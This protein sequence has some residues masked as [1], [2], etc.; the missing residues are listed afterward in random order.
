LAF[1]QKKFPIN[2]DLYEACE[3]IREE[4]IPAWRRF[5]VKVALLLVAVVFVSFQCW[6]GV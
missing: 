6:G 4:E 5:C 3:M 2:A 1:P